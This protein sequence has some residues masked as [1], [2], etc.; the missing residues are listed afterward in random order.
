MSVEGGGVADDPYLALRSDTKV[1]SALFYKISGARARIVISISINILI[2]LSMLRSV[3]SF[4][5]AST[6]TRLPPA[7]SLFDVLPP[8]C[9]PVP[10]RACS[11]LS[12][13]S[14]TEVTMEDAP[15]FSLSLSL[16]LCLV[17][18]RYA[19]LFFYQYIF[20]IVYRKR[21]SYASVAT[22]VSTSLLMPTEGTEN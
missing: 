15:S 6:L 20:V 17:L 21:I 22:T 13:L 18:Y 4:T 9:H 11:L 12:L 16:S 19:S 10:R 3:V 8:S 2:K 1:A 14:N 7:S 5:A